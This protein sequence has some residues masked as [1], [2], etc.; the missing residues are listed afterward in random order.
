MEGEENLPNYL[1]A[2]PLVCQIDHI[3]IKI[4]RL[5]T[6]RNHTFKIQASLGADLQN[7]YNAAIM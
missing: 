1:N 2:E 5:L 7:K 4:E 3:Y 6:F